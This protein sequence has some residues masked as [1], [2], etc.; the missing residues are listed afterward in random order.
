MRFKDVIG[1]EN[2]KEQLRQRVRTESVA[3]ANLFL[4][5]EGCGTWAMALAFARY[6]CCDHRD[7]HDACGTCDVCI[8]FDT[9]QYADLHFTYPVYKKDSGAKGTSSDFSAEWRAFI[10]ETP[11]PR[12]VD[13]LNVLQAEKKSLRIYVA[14]AGEI[15]RRLA[16][17]SYEGRYNIQLI[18][19]PEYMSEDTANKL[20]KLIEEPPLQTLFLLVSEST[21]RILPTILSRTQLVKLPAIDDESVE[22]ALMTREN[23]AQEPARDIARFVEGN[24]S[25]ALEI[26]RNTEGQAAFLEVFREWMR[27]CY[28]RDAPKL[29][30]LSSDLGGRAR[31]AQKQFLNYALYFIRQC[32]VFNYSGDD[33]ARFTSGEAAFAQRFAPFINDRNVLKMNE[34]INDSIHDIMGNVSGKIVFLDLSLKLHS[35]LRK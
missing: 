6:A 23:I 13:W 4:G 9:F 33:L 27:A 26:V 5:P 2:I 16:L 7:E 22:T 3:H 11:Y 8:K 32:I 14:E 25:R 20:L 29:V 31:E 28:S 17:K 35:E 30:A 12:Y 15:N 19:L 18:W 34:L 10:A 21:E 24:Y 1:H